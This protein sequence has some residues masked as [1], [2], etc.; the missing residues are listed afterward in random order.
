MLAILGSG[1]NFLGMTS[2]F[3][4][5]QKTLSGSSTADYRRNSS[6]TYS[7]HI[8]TMVSGRAMWSVSLRGDILTQAFSSSLAAAKRASKKWC[9]A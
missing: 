8:I 4:R 5:F 6:E 3:S 9:E 2:K 1:G 7:I